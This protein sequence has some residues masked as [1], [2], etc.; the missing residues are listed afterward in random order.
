[1]WTGASCVDL[2]LRLATLFLLFAIGLLSF[3][4][5]SYLIYLWTRPPS[6][7]IGAFGVA[8][9]GDGSKSR[10]IAFVLQENFNE[11]L[12]ILSWNPANSKT[13]GVSIPEGVLGPPLPQGSI[14][15][16]SKL[17]V[18]IADIEVSGLLDKV[19]SVFRRGPRIEGMVMGGGATLAIAVEYSDEAGKPK[20]TWLV[21]SANL[22]QDLRDLAYNIVLDLDKEGSPELNSLN[23]SQFIALAEG[24][25]LL[26]Q[27]ADDAA[28]ADRESQQ[29][30][31][32]AAIT[33]LKP[34]ADSG[35]RCIWFYKY[36][37]AAYKLLHDQANAETYLRKAEELEPQDVF[38]AGQ[39]K[40][41]RT[42]AQGAVAA[43]PVAN[44]A[45]QPALAIARFA[46]AVR[47]LEALKTSLVTVVD[48]DSGLDKQLFAADRIL[49]GVST[50]PS[51][52]AVTDSLG[53]GT[54]NASIVLNLCPSSR[55]Y[56]IK[57]FSNIGSGPEEA[58]LEG[59]RAAS[60]SRFKLVLLSFGSRGEL[61]SAFNA[62]MK[63]LLDSG[64]LVIAPA[65]NEG[66]SQQYYPAA[67]PGVISVAAVTANGLLADFSTYGKWV[68]IAAPGVGLV[69]QTLNGSKQELSGT[70]MA[71]SV[72]AAAAAMV[73]S[74]RPEL[75]A[76]QVKEILVTTATPLNVD[77]KGRSIS[78]GIV[79]AQKAVQ[80]ATQTH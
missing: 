72:V 40:T 30:L 59:V 29:S 24:K 37:S 42:K 56:P 46:E 17:G 2:F 74:V 28:H 8:D 6:I 60:K 69:G 54:F 48:L 39:L 18:K 12:E 71:A 3:G 32:Q 35:T 57:I 64:A 61:S 34:I 78:S 66:G 19:L 20:H 15:S 65:G 9:G 14:V 80:Q 26:K 38:V 49:D 44:F 67:S 62:E 52:T 23:V 4:G 55:I 27:Y 33:A 7:Q 25:R 47:Q 43:P 76:D 31:A 77:S 51:E 13:G 11:A 1:M 79:N 21:N 70:S 50:I 73:W 68:T 22:R 58:L 41:I 10:A 36:L 5:G 63:N 75:T 53:H 45:S 16:E